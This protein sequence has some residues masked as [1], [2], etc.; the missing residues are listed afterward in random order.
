MAW[1]SGSAGAAESAMSDRGMPF[2]R[3]NTHMTAAAAMTAP[4]MPRP[5]S[6]I[7]QA[8]PQLSLSWKLRQSVTTW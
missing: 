4:G 5:P 7:C 8:S 3:A 1:P 2:R 6:Q